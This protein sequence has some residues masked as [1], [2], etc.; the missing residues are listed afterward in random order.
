MQMETLL[1]HFLWQTGVT[2][3]NKTK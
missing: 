2:K 3:T 1:V